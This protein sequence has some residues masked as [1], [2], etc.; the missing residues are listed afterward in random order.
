MDL[1]IANLIEELNIT[2]PILHI[3]DKLYLIGPSRMTCEMKRDFV[4]LRVG[5]GYEKF[6]E[7]LPRNHRFYERTLVVHMIKSGESLEWVIDALFNGRQIRSIA[8]M[9]A[10]RKS[11][12]R[13]SSSGLNG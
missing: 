11:N 13:N 10:A 7:H 8:N 9:E 1:A 5:G 2:L 3:K 6:V 4:M 12:I